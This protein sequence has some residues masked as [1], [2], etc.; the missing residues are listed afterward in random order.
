GRLTDAARFAYFGLDEPPKEAVTGF[1][2]GDPVDRRVR[3]VIAPGPGAEVVEA[4]VDVNAR[5]VESFREVPEMRP[6]LLF[7]ESYGAIVALRDNPEWQA[8]LARRGITDQTKVQI[9]PWPA[10]DFRPAPQE[11]GR[12]TPPPP[13]HREHHDHHRHP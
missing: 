12:V 7:E 2:P 1:A 11:G 6:A 4:I 8:A 10:G 9:D 13:C 5:A 3:V